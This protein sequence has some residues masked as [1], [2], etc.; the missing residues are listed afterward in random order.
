MEAM[1]KEDGTNKEK[2]NLQE[3]DSMNDDIADN[4]EKMNLELEV[5]N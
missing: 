2:H 5:E 1:N 4:F 3:E